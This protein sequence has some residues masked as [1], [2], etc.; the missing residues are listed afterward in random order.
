MIIAG[1]SAYPRA[2]DFKQIGAIAKEVGAL[3]LTDIS[4]LSGSIAA[5]LHQNPLPFADIVTSTTHKSLRGPRSAFIIHRRDDAAAIQRAVMPGYQGGPHIHTIAGA[6]VAAHEACKKS[7]T[8]YMKRVHACA[9][10][11]ADELKKRGYSLVSNGTDTHLLLVHLARSGFPAKVHGKYAEELLEQAG[12]IA[13]RNTV[14]F[15]TKS[16][17]FGSGVRFGLPALVTRGATVAHMPLLGEL[18]DNALREKE[19]AQN[20]KRVKELAQQLRLPA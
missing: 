10:A 4:H 2:I 11:L 1:G 16:P 7:F 5:G 19:K 12:I 14:P 18:I 3:L 6:A 15:E 8:T 17:R 9:A 13:N 20:K